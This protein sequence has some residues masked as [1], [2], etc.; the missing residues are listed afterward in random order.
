MFERIKYL[1]VKKVY[2]DHNDSVRVRRAL[3]K[4]FLSLPNDFKGLNIGAGKTRL[5]SNISNL[6]IEP[7]EGIDLVGSV[8]S[9]PCAND[10]FDIVISQ[11]V[12]EHVNKPDEA[13]CEMYRVLKKGGVLYLQLP[14]IIGY[15]PCPHDYWRFSHEGIY[16]LVSRVSFEIIESDI[17]VGPASG[18]YRVLVE[19]FAVLASIIWQGF[20]K[21]I[22]FLT[23]LIFYPVKWLDPLLMKSDENKRIAGGFYIVCRKL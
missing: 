16:E 12:L 9:I 3:Q 21:P 15:H 1:F 14:F 23:A 5:H 19:F 6:E 2:A 18:F 13:I 20:Y 22:K 11:E 7:G 8:L 17:T 4:I 10:S